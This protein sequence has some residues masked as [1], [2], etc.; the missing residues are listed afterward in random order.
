MI[1]LQTHDKKYKNIFDINNQLNSKKYTTKPERIM[2]NND[3]FKF[4][5]SISDTNNDNK[6]ELVMKFEYVILGTYRENVWMWAS[7]STTLNKSMIDNCIQI[8]KILSSNFT[9]NSKIMNFINKTYTTLTTDE[10]KDIM[11]QISCK[12]YDNDKS[13]VYIKNG[14]YC[15]IFLIKKILLNRL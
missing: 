5:L 8:K 4:I 9:E 15:D 10:M 6:K 14:S 1:I 2:I 12:L 7:E 3:E 13:F 11:V